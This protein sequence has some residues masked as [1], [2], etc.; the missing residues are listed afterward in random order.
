MSVVFTAEFVPARAFAATCGCPQA[1]ALAPDHPTFEAADAAAQAANLLP[2]TALPG[3]DLADI[4]PDYPLRAEAVDPDAAPVVDVHNRNAE[5]LLELLGL[6]GELEAAGARSPAAPPAPDRFG[7]MDAE[8]F[9]GRALMAL[10][11][12]PEDAGS[13]GTWRGRVFTGG[14]SAGHLQR[15]L[16]E[17]HD[18]AQWC[19]T[20]GRTVTWG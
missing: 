16:R 14:R 8:A 18:L 5:R 15:R 3:C 17:L 1:T 6:E 13:E 19:A 9:L 7:E 11:L 20:R 10:A 4:C 2:R 12:T